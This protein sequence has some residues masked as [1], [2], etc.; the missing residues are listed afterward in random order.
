MSWP[1][2]LAGG[3]VR[4]EQVEERK[5]AAH[6][7]VEILSR[8]PE[9]AAVVCC[10]YGPTPHGVKSANDWEAIPTMKLID[11]IERN[12]CPLT[13]YRERNVAWA[14]S[15]VADTRDWGQLSAWDDGKITEVRSPKLFLVA[16]IEYPLSGKMTDWVIDVMSPITPN[17][18]LFNTGGGGHLVLDKLVKP[19]DLPRHWGKLVELFVI[20]G[21][22]HAPEQFLRW[23]H[24]LQ[25]WTDRP[26]GLRV[27]AEELLAHSS[28]YD[29]PVSPK[30]AFPVDLKYL[31][32][33]LD[34]LA[35]LLEGKQ[36]PV[37]NI[38][39]SNLPGKHIDSPALAAKKTGVL[40]TKYAVR[41]D[42]FAGSQLELQWSI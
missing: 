31:G 30:R 10:A 37:A 4:T 29:D 2:E 3:M 15:S 34:E 33:S 40:V 38:R 1:A 36:T 22:I 27:I 23:A 32:H 14:V 21:M 39:V 7:W 5:T 16:D 6:T 13:D 19:N 35:D 28:H 8:H 24:A 17:W 9:V 18:Y 41:N 42:T 12:R 11:Y 25:S 26:D 20:R